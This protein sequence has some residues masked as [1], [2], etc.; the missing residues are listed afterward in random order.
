MDVGRPPFVC[1]PAIASVYPEVP[2][3]DRMMFHNLSPPLIQYGPFFPVPERSTI[4][5]NPGQVGPGRSFNLIQLLGIFD[6]VALRSRPDTIKTH[7][8]SNVRIRSPDGV[9]IGIYS[10][11]PEGATFGK[12]DIKGGGKDK[13]TRVEQK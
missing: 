5:K 1:L 3:L 9:N 10:S 12:K 4:V 13:D 11:I 2:D 7:C 8:V 6:T